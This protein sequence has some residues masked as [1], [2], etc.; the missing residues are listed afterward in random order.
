MSKIFVDVG[1]SLDGYVAGPNR[2]PKNPLGD[3]GT[4][5]HQWAFQLMPDGDR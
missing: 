4:G 2:G 5:I 3:R 1:V